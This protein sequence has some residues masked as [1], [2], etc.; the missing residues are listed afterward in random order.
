M[1][2]QVY[3]TWNVTNW[4]TVVLMVAISWWVITGIAKMAGLTDNDKEP[5]K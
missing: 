5:A 4:V 2:E 3:L 1:E